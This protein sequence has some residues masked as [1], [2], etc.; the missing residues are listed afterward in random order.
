[1][2]PRLIAVSKSVVC[3]IVAGLCSVNMIS[4][5]MTDC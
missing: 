3:V 4:V 2:L 5:V 1:M